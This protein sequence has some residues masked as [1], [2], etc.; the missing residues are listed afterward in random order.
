MTSFT[1]MAEKE[2]D[3][4]E[5]ESRETFYNSSRIP[6][7]IFKLK[8]IVV[9]IQPSPGSG[10]NPMVALEISLEGGSSEVLLEIKDREGEVLDQ[11]QRTV[12]GYTFEDLNEADG[13]KEMTEKVRSTV[14]R[15]LTLGKIRKA[16]IQG[17]IL[18][19]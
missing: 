13:K 14:N 6:K 9:N 17:F 5:D 7:N 4:S 3:I 18:K 1:Q 10:P 11:V 16:Y 8:K 2:W 12:E 15:L 19:P